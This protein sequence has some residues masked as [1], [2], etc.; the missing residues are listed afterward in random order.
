MTVFPQEVAPDIL[1]CL[2]LAGKVGSRAVCLQWHNLAHKDVD[3]RVH[4]VWVA[5]RT[6]LAT[7]FL[8]LLRG[9]NW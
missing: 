5:V 2:S 9:L 7:S 1:A 3:Y 6:S 4:V 8:A